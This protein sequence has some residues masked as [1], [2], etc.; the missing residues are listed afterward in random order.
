MGFGQCIQSKI[1]F[2]CIEYLPFSS[3]WEQGKTLALFI[4][5][6]GEFYTKNNWNRCKIL[7]I[8]DYSIENLGKTPYTKSVRN[9][10]CMKRCQGGRENENS[11]FAY[12]APNSKKQGRKNAGP[13]EG[14]GRPAV[15]GDPGTCVFGDFCLHTA[16]RTGHCL[17]G[18]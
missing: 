13:L 11:A 1:L 2:K 3:A 4:F 8:F 6:H 9:K 16:D 15:H 7:F 17:S 12:R 14:T 18:F 10:E 5:V